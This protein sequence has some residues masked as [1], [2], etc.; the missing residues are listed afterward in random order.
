MDEFGLYINS[1]PYGDYTTNYSLV[2]P[3]QTKNGEWSMIHP[4]NL[5]QLTIIIRMD[6]YGDFNFTTSSREL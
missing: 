4:L 6:M 2:N 5:V 3:Q 1:G